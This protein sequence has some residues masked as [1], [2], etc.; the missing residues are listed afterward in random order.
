MADQPTRE[1]IEQIGE[2]LAADRTV[3]AIKI[4][5]EATG[6]DLR[7]AKEFVDALSLRLK[8]QGPEKYGA[9]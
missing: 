8:E 7:A 5:R 6:K 9:V 2:A 1:Q 3:L 4:Y